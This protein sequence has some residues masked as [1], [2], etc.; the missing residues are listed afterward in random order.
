MQLNIKKAR[1]SAIETQRQMS[2]QLPPQPTP[3]EQTVSVID[4]SLE[5]TGDLQSVGKIVVN[6]KVHGNITCSAITISEGAS[7]EGS[8][9]AESITIYGS[10]RGV[11]RA[12]NI[13]LQS[14][15]HVFGHLIHRELVIEEGAIFEGTSK[16]TSD[17]KSPDCLMEEALADLNAI[18]AEMRAKLHDPRSFRVGGIG[19]VA[20]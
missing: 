7:L 5:V 8:I 14:S 16:I 6:G 18:G 2:A 10:A 17:P 4:G 13:Q 19:S 3:V 11:F 9:V 12:G 15:S 20:A 1:S